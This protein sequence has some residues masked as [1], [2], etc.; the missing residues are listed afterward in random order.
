MRQKVTLKGVSLQIYLQTPDHRSNL[1]VT[2]L[3]V[4]CV[5]IIYFMFLPPFSGGNRCEWIIS[6]IFGESRTSPA[7]L[8]DRPWPWH[9]CERVENAKQ[10]GKPLMK[11]QLCH[12]NV[13]PLRGQK[14]QDK[15]QNVNTQEK[16]LNSA[17]SA[18]VQRHVGGF[19]FTVIQTEEGRTWNQSVISG[20][21]LWLKVSDSGASLAHSW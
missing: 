16:K 11:T 3:W 4:W 14:V 8:P 19:L 1:K 18:F 17:G 7:T 12:R 9:F 13:N 10:A 15:K 20:V 21:Q 5:W 2:F 6:H